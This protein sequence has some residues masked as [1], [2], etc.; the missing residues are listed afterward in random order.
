M[1][2]K[3]TLWENSTTCWVSFCDLNGPI[4]TA[5]EQI[6]GPASRR[7]VHNGGWEK[8][9]KMHKGLIRT[10]T[11]AVSLPEVFFFFSFFPISTRCTPLK[12]ACKMAPPRL[13]LSLY[14]RDTLT[15]WHAVNLCCHFYTLRHVTV[16]LTVSKDAWKTLQHQKPSGNLKI[17]LLLSLTTERKDENASMRLVT[18]GV[19]SHPAQVSQRML[20]SL[21]EISF[22]YEPFLITLKR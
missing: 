12:A 13:L 19:V 5:P 10:E 4:I 22:L 8:C 20:Q 7:S 15:V 18:K 16:L 9:D 1:T 21:L 6:N 17:N 14:T 11:G 3:S 2:W